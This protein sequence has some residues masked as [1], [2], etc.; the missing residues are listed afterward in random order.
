MTRRPKTLAQAPGFTQ[1]EYLATLEAGYETGWWNE[2]GVPAPWPDDFLD[3]NSGWR[4]YS[5]HPAR[6]LPDLLLQNGDEPPF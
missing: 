3:P 4:C 6:E 2:R 1:A 5:S